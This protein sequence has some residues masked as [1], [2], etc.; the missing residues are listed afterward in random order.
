MSHALC[1]Y[2][3]KKRKNPDCYPD[4]LD[5][6]CVSIEKFE[7]RGDKSPC[8]VCQRRNENPKCMPQCREECKTIEAYQGELLMREYRIDQMG[9]S[10]GV[11]ASDY[12]RYVL[13]RIH[14]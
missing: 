14:K 13:G 6:G 2:C 4:C 5:E 9:H 1:R 3:K 11:D 7:M 12:G 10:V 8:K